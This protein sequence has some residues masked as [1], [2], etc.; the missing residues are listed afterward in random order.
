MVS[1]EPELPFRPYIPA[2]WS[3]HNGL[4]S[5]SGLTVFVVG[6]LGLSLRGLSN[7][8]VNVYCKPVHLSICDLSLRHEHIYMRVLCVF[9]TRVM[10]YGYSAIH[11]VYEYIYFLWFSNGTCS[12]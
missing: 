10:Q 3:P 9:L 2:N 11:D 12:Q 7:C 8:Y 1:E 6:Y 4:V 5:P